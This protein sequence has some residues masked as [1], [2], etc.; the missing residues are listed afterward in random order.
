MHHCIDVDSSICESLMKL[1]GWWE[2]KIRR[3]QHARASTIELQISPVG[4]TC[5]QQLQNFHDV[6]C[7]QVRVHL[8]TQDC[9]ASPGRYT[10]VPHRTMVHQ[11]RSV[12]RP[13][14]R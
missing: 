12:L 11:L 3:P 1:D 7:Q 9:V 4:I 2:P 10:A 14:G 6:A 8:D 13:G 5:K